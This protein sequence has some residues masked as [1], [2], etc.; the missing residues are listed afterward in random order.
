[1]RAQEVQPLTAARSFSKWVLA[2][3]V[4]P[5]RGLKTV[6]ERPNTTSLLQEL[7]ADAELPEV[8]RARFHGSLRT[9]NALWLDYRSF[10]RQGISNYR[11]ATAVEDRSAFLLYYYAMLNFAK[12]ELL[13]SGS[14]SVRGRV[15]HGLSFDPTRARTVAGDALLV[16][17]G[18]FR[19]LYEVRTGYVLP[20]KARLPVRRLLCQVPEIRSQLHQTKVGS[21][22]VF[23]VLQLLAADTTDAWALLAVDSRY[24]P[25]KRTASGGLLLRTFE[26]VDPPDDWRDR[27]AVSRRGLGIRLFQHRTRFGHDPADPASLRQAFAKAADST[28]AIGDI[29][30]LSTHGMWDG[31]LAPSLYRTKMMPMPPALARYALAF[32]A[33][34]LVRYRPSM[35]DFEM[36]PDQAF[37]FDGMA[38]EFSVPMLID[39]VSAIAQMDFAWVAEDAFRN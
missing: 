12:A 19:Q 3:L 27:F 25:D 10:L 13:A 23:G 5:G 2:P 15:M 8:G 26:E 4:R 9:R 36:A 34:S 17:D 24:V 37:L 29:L 28:W 1:M 18:V 20:L 22:G 33:S 31:W 14:T 32:Y 11:A 39:T 16:T 38:R 30:G 6:F 35:F 7:R 21:V